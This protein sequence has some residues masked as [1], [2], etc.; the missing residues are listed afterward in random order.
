[1]PAL[2]LKVLQV[3]VKR[4]RERVW[5]TGEEKAAI[6]EEYGFCCAMCGARGEFEFDHIA[7]LSESYD[8]QRFQPLCVRATGRR[9]PMNL[10]C[11]MTTSWRL[12]S[13]ERFGS[14]I[15]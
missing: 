2:S 7:R 1:L 4:N 9:L 5:L 8:E 14:S 12:T 13:K 11:T 3:P 6:L 15:L 10:E